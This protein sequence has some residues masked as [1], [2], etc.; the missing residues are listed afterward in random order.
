MATTVPPTVA[1]LFSL[2]GKTAIVTG[3]T[4][5]LGLAMTLALAE[6][7]ADIISIELPND[8]LSADLKTQVES[9]G[10]SIT[11]YACNVADSKALRGTFA[12]ISS[13]RDGHAADI[14]LN[15]AGIQR[16]GK[17]E[18]YDDE[19]IEAVFDINLKATFVAGQEFAKQCIGE[20]RPGKVVNVASIIS[21]ISSTT[22]APYAATK[23]AVLQ[24]T[25]AFSS[26]WAV[27]DGMEVS[28]RSLASAVLLFCSPL[29]CF[30]ASAFL[31]PYFLASLPPCFPASLLLQRCSWRR[32]LMCLAPI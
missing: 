32:Q 19:T 10:R 16:R 4:G 3:G 13:D 5:G 18:E 28:F 17:A 25:K 14:L 30:P 7:G 22:I 31:L 29:S 1:E 11:S 6:G 27:S 8:P 21:F 12:S 24:T 2:T 26:E 20:G 23:G 15:C 9:H